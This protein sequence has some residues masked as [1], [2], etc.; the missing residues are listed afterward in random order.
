MRCEICQ[1]LLLGFIFDQQRLGGRKKNT[2][3]ESGQITKS[4]GPTDI[5]LWLREP[6]YSLVS[7]HS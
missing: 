3:S 1:D 6:P 5:A 7:P 2:E 4:P